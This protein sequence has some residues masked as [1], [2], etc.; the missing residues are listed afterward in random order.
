MRDVGGGGALVLQ[1]R[2]SRGTLGPAAGDRVP[3][4]GPSLGGEPDLYLLAADGLRDL[5]QA[6]GKAF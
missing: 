2:R 4:T 1:C 6:G 5:R 3:L